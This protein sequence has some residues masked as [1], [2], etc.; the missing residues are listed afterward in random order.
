MFV[1]HLG[2]GL[3]AKAVEPRLRLSTTFAAAMLLDL[4]LW[5][6]VLTGIEAATTPADYAS[7]HYLL[8]NFPYSHSL[9]AAVVWSVAAALAWAAFNRAGDIRQQ[10][11]SR[12]A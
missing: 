6:F 12:A 5:I 1:G 4:V 9:V 10:P 8:F 2:A 3:I 11:F 7:H